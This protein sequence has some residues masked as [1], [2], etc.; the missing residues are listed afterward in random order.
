M[1]EF[2]FLFELFTLLISLAVAEVLGGFARILKL[3]ARR[4]AGVDPHAI[5][6]RVGWL[7]PLLGLLVLLDLATFWNIMWGAREV[8]D[9]R[10][11]MVFG[12]L[13]LIGGYY[14]VST[15]VFPD[16]PELWPDFDAYFWQQKPVVVWGILALNLAA[17]GAIMALGGGQAQDPAAMQRFVE[18]H[19]LFS[20]A[21]LALLFNFPAFAWLALTKGKRR[22]IALMA[23]VIATQILFAISSWELKGQL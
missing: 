17:Q 3:R 7:V 12:V 5:R 19:P 23:F 22:A 2:P 6:V 20:F 21:S 16:E 15:L 18:S 4:K 14:L 11:A 13:T 10:M 1:D 8:L 9:M